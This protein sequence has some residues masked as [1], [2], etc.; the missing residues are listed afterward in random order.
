MN[1]VLSIG[2]V[3]KTKGGKT[4]HFT[5]STMKIRDSAKMFFVN[6]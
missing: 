2:F 6:V 5:L 3:I 1:F 4:Y